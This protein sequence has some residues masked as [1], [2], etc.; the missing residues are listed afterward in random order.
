MDK[1]NTLKWS[2]MTN[3]K[4]QNNTINSYTPLSW[5]L[6]IKFWWIDQTWSWLIMVW[7][8]VAIL[9]WRS[10][11]TRMRLCTSVLKYRISWHLLTSVSRMDR[12]SWEKPIKPFTQALSVANVKSKYFIVM[13]I[14]V[15]VRTRMNMMGNLS[16]MKLRCLCNRMGMS[17]LTANS[18]TLLYWPQNPYCS[19]IFLLA[20]D[21][22]IIVQIWASK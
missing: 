12:R 18:F 22:C 4:Y 13:K 16:T 10:T 20:L 3:S 11:S 14:K 8:P 15:Q 6:W 7:V 21:L 2:K 9:P 1:L 17:S 19:M 5:T